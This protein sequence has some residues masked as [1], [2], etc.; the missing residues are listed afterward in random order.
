V[1]TARD[2]AERELSLPIFPGMT[3]GEVEHVVHAVNQC[4]DERRRPG[5]VASR[6]AL[7]T[8]AL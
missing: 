3:R 2:W 7:V 8:E 1:A 6:R 4:T 5:S